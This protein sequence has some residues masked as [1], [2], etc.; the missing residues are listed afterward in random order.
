[1]ASKRR[2]VLL[3]SVSIASSV[4]RIKARPRKV[5]LLS[6]TSFITGSDPYLPVPTTRRLHFHGVRDRTWG[7]GFRPDARFSHS[8]G[9]ILETRMV[10]V[11]LTSEEAEELHGI[12]TITSLT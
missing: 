11:E 4:G 9:F 1:V 2:S 5:D 10:R 8:N 6:L 3:A 7:G 12:L